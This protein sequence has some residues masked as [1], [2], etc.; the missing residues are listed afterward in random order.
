M[1]DTDRTVYQVLYDFDANDTVELSV[2]AG[3]IVVS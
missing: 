1:T 2:K 3:E